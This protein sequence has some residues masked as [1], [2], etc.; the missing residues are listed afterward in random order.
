MRAYQVGCY[1]RS[2]NLQLPHQLSVSVF[3]DLFHERLHDG[4]TS[5]AQNHEL[6]R[7]RPVVMLKLNII[8]TLS[9]LE[10]NFATLHTKNSIVIKIEKWQ[11][12]LIEGLFR[13]AVRGIDHQQLLTEV[14]ISNHSQAENYIFLFIRR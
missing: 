4:T 14:F 11:I 2:G 9:M 12:V 10:T 13:V 3:S 6:Q 1:M 7:S 8:V 5:N